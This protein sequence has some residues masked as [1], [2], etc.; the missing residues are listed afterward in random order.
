M[1]T[2]FSPPPPSTRGPL[3]TEVPAVPAL[4][5]ER[6]TK[7]FVV[8]RRKPPVVAVR[9]VS[10]LLP[11]GG[12]HGVL[13]ANGSGKS[14]LIR[15]ICGLLTLDEG[16]VEVFG[17]DI[18]RG[19]HATTHRE[20][21]RLATGVL[22]VDTPGMREL[23]LWDAADGLDGTFAEI[24]E[25]AH[26]CRF[27]DCRH[28]REPGCAIRAALETGEIDE[29]RLRSYRRLSAELAVRPPPPLR[30]EAAKRFQRAVR[31]ASAESMARKSYRSWES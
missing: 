11:R 13:G 8:D 25:I 21:F 30:R 17:H 3:G 28:E 14:T 4:L 23:G 5:V 15:L 22:L 16:R 6:A 10:L 1:T 26:R 19:R 24:A 7:R 20:L 18:A 12:I 29:R 2:I 9:D 27:R 31:D